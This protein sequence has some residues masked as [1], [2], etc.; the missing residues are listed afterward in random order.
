MAKR[1]KFGMRHS[2]K[3]IR[4]RASETLLDRVSELIE[5]LLTEI[6]GRCTVTQEVDRLTIL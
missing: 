1:K 5:Q 4:N 2:K 6:T 3:A